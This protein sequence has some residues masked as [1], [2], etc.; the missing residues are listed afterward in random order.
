[1]NLPSGTALVQQ[2][3]TMD[4]AQ[5]GA[6]LDMYAPEIDEL[7]DS[8]DLE[9]WLGLSARSLD[10]QRARQK[11]SWPEPARHFGVTPVWRYRTIAL[12]LASRPGKGNRSNH[13]PRD[14]T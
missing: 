14:Q 2:L 8:R 4:A 1:M 9:T 13:P 6:H 10:R 5:R 3:R 7:A 11:D 12:Y